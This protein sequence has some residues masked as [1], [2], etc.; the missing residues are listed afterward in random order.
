MK[1]HLP[2]TQKG[3]TLVEL[4]VVVGILAILL[5][6]IL[7]A[8]N[9]AKRFQ[10]TNNAVRQSDVNTI[11]NAIHQYIAENKGTVPS[12]ITTTVKPIK[13]SSPADPANEADLCASLVANGFLGAIPVDP[14]QG[15]NNMTNWSSCT[16]TYDSKYT[17]VRN[18]NG[19]ITVASS[20]V[21]SI[22][23]TR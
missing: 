2:K 18:A 22:T 16:G 10:E 15:V 9:P 11:L 23:A 14:E 5:A 8:L 1:N 21:P 7:V 19:T 3:F 12:A 20:V 6:V 17:V 13:L 4:I